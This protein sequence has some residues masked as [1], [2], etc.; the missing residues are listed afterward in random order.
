VARD[1][2]YQDCEPVVAR[3]AAARLRPQHW[4]IWKE[5][6]PL[7]DWPG[8]ATVGYA[9]EHD[10][11]LGGEGMVRGSTRASAPLSWLHSGHSPML[12]M[13]GRLA[14]VLAE[15]TGELTQRT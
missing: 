12:S 8:I 7:I 15:V 10:H 4:G 11:M 14:K 9:C 6:C 3:T 1:L 13:P 5:P 2:L